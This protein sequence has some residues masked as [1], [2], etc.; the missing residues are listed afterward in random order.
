MDEA[1][2]LLAQHV[3]VA[4]A[5]FL[6]RAGLEILDQHVGVASRRSSTVAPA[7]RREV[8]RDAALVA[9]DADEIG[10]GAVVEGRA[11]AARLVARGGS[12]LITSAPW[13]ARICVQY[14]PPST[15]VR[16]IT[17]RPVMAGKG[18]FMEATFERIG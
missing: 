17:R 10:R 12:T 11:P 14:G 6:E 3:L 4:D 8:E 9:V 15:R 2:E 7:L 5:P 18:A 16:S 13:S 1:R